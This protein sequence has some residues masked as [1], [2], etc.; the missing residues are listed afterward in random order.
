MARPKFPIVSRPIQSAPR[1]FPWMEIA[2]A[3]LI[4]TGAYALS[5]A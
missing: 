4:A 1:R 3:L 2:I 5:L